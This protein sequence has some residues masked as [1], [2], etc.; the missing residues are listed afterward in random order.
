MKKFVVSLFFAFCATVSFANTSDADLAKSKVEL[1]S[2]SV[3][4]KTTTTN[5]SFFGCVVEDI[6]GNIAVVC[7]AEDKKFWRELYCEV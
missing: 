2:S 4:T 5:L 3:Q 1:N 6:C 7:D